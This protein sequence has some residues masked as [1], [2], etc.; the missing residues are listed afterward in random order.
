[1]A[2]EDIREF[3]QEEVMNLAF[4]KVDFN[5]SLI[6]SKLLDSISIIDLI[7]SIEEKTG[8]K[9]PQHLMKDENF[10]SINQIIHTLDQI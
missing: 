7:V 4:K 1:M 8:K 10:D 6:K 5:Q 3:I 9:I 2:V